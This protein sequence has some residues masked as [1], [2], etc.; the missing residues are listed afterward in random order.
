MFNGSLV[1][2]NFRKIPKSWILFSKISW[3]VLS[4]CRIE[5][6]ETVRWDCRTCQNKISCFNMTRV[7]LSV[8]HSLSNTFLSNCFFA[9]ADWILILCIFFYCAISY[10]LIIQYFKLTSTFRDHHSQLPDIFP[11]LFKNLDNYDHL[12]INVKDMG[13]SVGDGGGGGGGG[14]EEYSKV[15]IRAKF[16][17]NSCKLWAVFHVLGQTFEEE[18]GKCIFLSKQVSSLP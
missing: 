18:F 14:W 9:Y 13:I 12:K 15:I 6:R 8:N 11:L 5:C 10:W 1:N 4:W 2:C 3:H 17:W 16:G 7:P